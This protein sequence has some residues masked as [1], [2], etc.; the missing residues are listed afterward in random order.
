MLLSGERDPS[1]VLPSEGREEGAFS[2][3]NPE[4][5]SA[6]FSFPVVAVS[7]VDLGLPGGA[8]EP[9]VLLSRDCPAACLRR[10]ARQGGFTTTGDFTE[11][12]ADP[13]PVVLLGVAASRSLDVAEGLKVSF[14][15]TCGPEKRFGGGGEG[16]E[17]A[18]S[19]WAA[20]SGGGGSGCS[21][22]AKGGGGAGGCAGSTGVG[23]QGGHAGSSVP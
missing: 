21:T 10:G 19:S 4:A 15:K 14:P 7:G 6:S 16:G 18:D 20:I 11:G 3:P 13:F 23:S 9:R 12:L 22:R 5:A 2:A 17:G 8:S 1:S